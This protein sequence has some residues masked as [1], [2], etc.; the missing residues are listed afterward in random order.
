MLNKYLLNEQKLNGR[1]PLLPFF[2]GTGPASWLVTWVL[3]KQTEKRGG[4]ALSA[5][6]VGFQTGPRQGRGWEGAALSPGL[7][8]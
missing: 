4:V 5:Q 3:L 1:N 8:P 6:P 7:S 2:P